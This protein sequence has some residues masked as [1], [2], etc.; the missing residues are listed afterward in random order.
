MSLSDDEWSV[1]LLHVD[2]EQGA[3]ALAQVC[4]AWYVLL[5]EQW[6]RECEVDLGAYFTAMRITCDVHVQ[7]RWV[8]RYKF[9]Q[10]AKPPLV[11]RYRC[12][13]CGT[14]IHHVGCCS[15]CEIVWRPSGGNKNNN[16]SQIS[17]TS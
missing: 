4:R 7:R 2:A 11:S 5:H 15:K 14:V 8:V 17:G 3:W 10:F 9:S 13:T 1:V 12:G 16:N 6:Q